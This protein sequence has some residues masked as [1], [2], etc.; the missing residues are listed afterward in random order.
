EIVSAAAVVQAD[1]HV[2]LTETVNAAAVV[3]TAAPVK[4]VVPSTKQ[5]RGVVIRNLEEESSAK[6]PTETKSKDKGKGIMVEEP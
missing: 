2:A 5:R 3:T 6:T 4:V 1:V